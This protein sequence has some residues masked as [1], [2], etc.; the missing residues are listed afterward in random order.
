MSTVP[1]ILEVDDIHTYYGDSHILQ[2]VRFA[3]ETGELVALLGR[4]AVGKTTT[5]RTLL[6]FAPPRRGTIRFAGQ[7]TNGWP[8]YRVARAGIGLVAQGKRIFPTLTVQE[9]LE[10]AQADGQ[11]TRDRVCGLF[12][13]L[14]ERRQQLAGSLSGG[15]QQ[16]LSMGRALVT[17]PRLLVL[18][19]PSE[20]LSPIMVNVVKDVLVQ[21]KQTGMSILLV[22]QNISL[23]VTTADRVLVM[24]KGAIVFE[25]AAGVLIA[26]PEVLHTFLGV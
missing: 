26:S 2:G 11:W 5:V 20:G 15:E 23:S 18:D 22:E 6:G 19:E 4:N 3:I 10:V 9:N 14:A 21:L 17:N 1:N 12:P 8:P 13:I 24:N 16:M 25:E 7:Q